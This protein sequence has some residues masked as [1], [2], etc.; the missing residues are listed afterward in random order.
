M[1]DSNIRILILK[2]LKY[3]HKIYKQIYVNINI[4]FDTVDS[5]SIS[6]VGCRRTG[7]IFFFVSFRNSG[8]CD[9]WSYIWDSSIHK[10]PI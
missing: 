6:D 7:H 2:E 8:F 3:N 9:M 1:L 4:L 10:I 5:V